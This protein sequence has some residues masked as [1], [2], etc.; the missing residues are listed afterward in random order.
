MP[1]TRC[2]NCNGS[3]KL[4]GGGMIMIDCDTCFG[5]GKISDGKV[6]IQDIK[7]TDS[8]REAVK[9]IRAMNPVITQVEAEKLFDDEFKS[10]EDK[11]IVAKKRMG[12]PP[13]AKVEGKL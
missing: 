2:M 13:K 10:Q 8:Y 4:M 9:N 7:N 6:T 11:P 3:G 5:K 12:R 1:I